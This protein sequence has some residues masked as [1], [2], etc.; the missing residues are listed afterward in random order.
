MK[1][2]APD[3]PQLDETETMRGFLQCIIIHSYG[4]MYD[5][6]IRAIPMEMPSQDSANE[7]TYSTLSHKRDIK[8]IECYVRNDIRKEL[9]FCLY[10]APNAQKSKEYYLE[11][12][13]ILF[14][15]C[16]KSGGMY[17]DICMYKHNDYLHNYVQ[18]PRKQ[19]VLPHFLNDYHCVTI[20]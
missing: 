11:C 18:L 2:Q 1:Y 9:S 7:V 13:E 8:D 5:D 20:I 3:Q 14:K 16:T 4:G 10:D 15:E 19:V 6:T 17:L 12:I